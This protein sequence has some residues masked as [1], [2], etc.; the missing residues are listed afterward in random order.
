MRTRPDVKQEVLIITDGRSNCGGDAIDEAQELQSKADVFGLMIGKH[1]TQGVDE[2]TSY[3]SLPLNQ[4]LFA[5]EN[6]QELKALVDLIAQDIN[7]IKCASFD[8]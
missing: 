3:V 2:L 4:H 7:L 6:F 8:L 5:V 1:T